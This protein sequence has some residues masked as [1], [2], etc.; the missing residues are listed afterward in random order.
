MKTEDDADGRISVPQASFFPSLAQL[1]AFVTASRQASISRAA[2]ELLRSQ[3]SITQSVQNLE[4]DLGVDLLRRTHQGCFLT[5]SGNVLF[6]RATSCFNRIEE[7]LRDAMRHVG[8]N[9][10]EAAALKYRV[11]RSQILSL[12]AVNEY[13]SLSQAAR[14]AEVAISSLHRSIKNLEA[15][16]GLTLLTSTVRGFAT[17]G[18]GAAVSAQF[19]LAVRELEWA[20]EEIKAR[21]GTFQGRL[22]VG[23]MALAGTN[24]IALDI[25]KFIKKYPDVKVIVVTGTYDVLLAK[26]REGSIDFLIGL[27]KNPPPADDVVERPLGDDPYVVAVSR[28]HPLA[29]RRHVAPQD[30]A[31]A[32]WIAPTA[33]R[34]VLERIFRGVGSPRFNLET[35]SIPAIFILLTSGNRVALLTRSELELDR[36]LGN[37]LAA[38]PY[39][40]PAPAAVMGVT[41][42]SAWRPTLLQ[43]AFLEF[44]RP[45]LKE[46]VQS[47]IGDLR[48][49]APAPR[50]ARRRKQ[51]A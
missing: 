6:A 33:R 12:T 26:L 45:D 35:H 36:F 44:L 37:H 8:S 16:L 25:D 3:S 39:D 42:R 13:G 19:R 22:L 49:K 9:E 17:N 29:S 50:T 48:P 10:E 31:S 1:R 27:L 32:D 20:E 40:V 34:G 24:F 43:R 7:G 21:S 18:I 47:P 5:P 30:L 11:T 23:A 28:D 46:L 15:Q 41:V 4:A 38:L 51:T 2:G 14:H